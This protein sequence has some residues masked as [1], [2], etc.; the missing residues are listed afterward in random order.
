MKVFDKTIKPRNP[1][2][3]A[4]RKRNA[5]AHGSYNEERS[6]RR[7]AKQRLHKMRRNDDWDV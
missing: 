6:E 4:A 5:G 7:K 3:V 2:A 1:L